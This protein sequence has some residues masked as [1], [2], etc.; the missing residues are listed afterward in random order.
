MKFSHVSLLKHVVLCKVLANKVKTKRMLRSKKK[1]L[2]GQSHLK[3]I[4][5][6]V[7]CNTISAHRSVVR[8]SRHQLLIQIAT[9]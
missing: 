5:V 8:I 2:D 6:V 7:L 9:P 4:A 1:N 3:S